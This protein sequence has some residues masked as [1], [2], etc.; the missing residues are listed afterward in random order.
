[1]RIEF[2]TI[3]IQSPKSAAAA[4]LNQF[5]ASHAVL[6]I[7]RHFVQDGQNS[8]WA[9]CVS[10]QDGHQVDSS[11]SKA[12]KID[13]KEVLNEKQFVVYAKLR[14]LRKAMADQEGVPAYAL[15]NNR[16][17]AEMV[18]HKITTLVELKKL[19]GIGDARADKYGQHF[20][21]IIHDMADM[22]TSAA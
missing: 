5:L 20:L 7:E 19:T 12:A 9:V 6:S 18:Q 14:D 16:Q 21:K 11:N 15:F 17:L 3:P 13:Y 2:F 8:V 1:M 10:Y 4:A 22:P